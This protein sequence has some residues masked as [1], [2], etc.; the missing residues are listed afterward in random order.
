MRRRASPRAIW[1]M[2]LHR[3]LR[4]GGHLSTAPNFGPR[5]KAQLRLGFRVKTGDRAASVAAVLK[6]PFRF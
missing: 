3:S 4:I 1:S 6:L 2:A 5:F